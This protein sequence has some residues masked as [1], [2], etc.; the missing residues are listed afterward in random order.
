MASRIIPALFS[1]ILR[2]GYILL[3]LTMASCA[4]VSVS[5]TIRPGP[6]KKVVLPAKIYIKNYEINEA[7]FDVDREGES[8]RKFKW[9]TADRLS[10]M[11]RR[12]IRR[13]I[14]PAT[15]IS[16]AAPLPQENAWLITGRFERVE[17]GSRALRTVVG[18][19]AGA[20]RMETATFVYDLR[21]PDPGGPILVIRTQG[22]SNQM[23]GLIGTVLGFNPFLFGLNVL[24][25]LQHGLVWDS[26]RTSREITAAMSEFLYQQ[27]AIS[28][29]EAYAAKKS[30]RLW[31]RLKP[32]PAAT[33]APSPTPSP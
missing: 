23:G 21:K 4:S 15:V 12:Q 8:L 33:P 19:G 20:T 14:A 16:K 27:G 3:V 18:F 5:E 25:N 26:N 17:Q 24:G 6:P 1:G 13:R 9:Q 31:G 2:G 7:G 22:G 32:K 11:L 28:E 30:G 10:R 29:D